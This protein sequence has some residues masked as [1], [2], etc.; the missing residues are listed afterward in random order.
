MTDPNYPTGNQPQQGGYYQQQQSPQQSQGDGY[1]Q[2]PAPE[3]KVPSRRL[4]NPRKILYI[5]LV[6]MISSFAMKQ[7]LVDLN[8][9]WSNSMLK[10]EKV[11][12][13]AKVEIKEIDSALDLIDTNIEATALE[14]AALRKTD[15]SKGE[16]DDQLAKLVADRAE[17]DKGLDPKRDEV[18]KKY[19]PLLLEARRSDESAEASKPGTAHTMKF[20][21]LVMELFKIISGMF[22]ILFGL[23]IVGDPE[24][25]RGMRTYAAVIAGILFL[26]FGVLPLSAKAAVGLN[27]SDKI[28]DQTNDV[29]RQ[30]GILRQGGISNAPE[31]SPDGK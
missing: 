1:P 27:T 25:P 22:C 9:H 8:G 23:R 14:I 15:N 24:Q 4:A 19:I 30:P 6:I 29:L 31:A 10:K 13:Q 20:L 11:E 12:A 5:G 3:P 2:Q 21:M 16:K 7:V 28:R 17:K 26:G 18:R